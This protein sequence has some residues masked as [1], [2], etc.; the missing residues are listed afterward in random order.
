MPAAWPDRHGRDPQ[1]GAVS[2]DAVRRHAAFDALV[3]AHCDRLCRYVFR[4]VQSR[5]V[6]EDLVQDVFLHFWERG[7]DLTVRD[8][9][10]YLYQ[11]ARNRALTYLRH[12][13]LH[14]RWQANVQAAEEAPT[15]RL[16]AEAEYTELTV[17]VERAVAALPERCREVFTMSREQGLTHAEIAHV[18]GLSPRTVE[19]HV[20]RALTMIRAAA[21]PYLALVLMITTVSRGAVL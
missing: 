2:E 20:W 12:I 6:A 8:P 14:E 16:S 17:A 19:S 1:G 10:P 21:A 9:L 4:Y 15:E 11:A 18:L 5:D 3:T 13:R 7:D